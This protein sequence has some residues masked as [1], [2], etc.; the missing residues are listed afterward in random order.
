MKKFIAAVA[1]A[2]SCGFIASAQ[3]TVVSSRSVDISKEKSQTQWIVR[4]GVNFAGLTGDGAEELDGKTAYD[5]AVSFQKPLSNFGMFWGMEL[6]LGSRGYSY[7]EEGGSSSYEEKFL[8][9]NVRFSPFTIGYAYN[10]TD[11]IKADIRL[12]GYASFDYIGSGTE[13]YNSSYG[14][15]EEDFDLGDIDDYNRFDAGINF[16]IGVWYNRFNLDFSL[17]RGF[18]EIIKDSKSYTNNFMIRVGYAF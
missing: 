4:A 5:V 6:G 15:D 3:S 16:G 2:L 14:E 1:I 17:Q 12:G 9:H 10:F 13:S 7:E 11:Q 8:A 18:C